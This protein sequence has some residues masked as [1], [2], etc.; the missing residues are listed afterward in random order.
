MSQILGMAQ[1][2]S[3]LLLLG[4]TRPMRVLVAPDSFTGSLSARE[5]ADAIGEGWAAG[6]PTGELVAMPMSDGGPGF[7]EVIA[8]GLRA[9]GGEPVSTVHTVTGP[10][11]EAVPA[12][13][14]WHE[15]IAYCEAA[16]ACGLH[17]VPTVERD[18]WTQTSRGLG[19]LIRAAAEAGAERVVVGLGG[20]GTADA[21]AGMLAALGAWAADAGGVET[22][23]LLQGGPARFGELALG[24][25]RPARRSVLEVDL[26]VAAD[27]DV[28]LLGP[29]GA[30]LGFAAQK[31]PDP[32]KVD[33]A[34]L[35]RLDSR[36]GA[37]AQLLQGV[38]ELPDLTSHPGAGAA[39]GLGWALMA[40]GA[41]MTLGID[42]VAATIGLDHQIAQADVV[43]TGEGRL[44]WQSRRG[45]VV[46]GVA[47]RAQEHGVPVVVMAG[48]AQLGAREAAAMG[49]TEIWAMT[50]HAGMTQALEDPFG[51]LHDLAR[52]VATQWAR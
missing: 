10:R 9:A 11:G 51:T 52:R 13:L 34:E 16:E 44:D 5:A 46:A 1:R 37:F 4:F 18:P 2:T 8:A 36:I 28:P 42:V 30:A 35:V 12:T 25:L 43:I 23:A 21:G 40:L 31:F 39:G 38:A 6:A 29:G 33:T 27:V 41:T 22:P 19:E 47:R 45:K 20:T 3:P 32:A 24:D 49:I 50:E 7:V 17:L 14:T 26:V 15:G 48:D